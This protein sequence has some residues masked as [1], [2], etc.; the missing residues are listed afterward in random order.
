[1]RPVARDSKTSERLARQRQLSTQA[2]RWVGWKL[3]E[4]GV[5]YRKNVKT[6][7]GSPDFANASKRWAVFVNGC[8]WHHH[9][10]CKRATI[11]RNNEGF[12]RSKFAANRSRDARAV[13]DLRRRGF[14]V[15][16]LW[17]CGLAASETRLRNMLEIPPHDSLTKITNFKGA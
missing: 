3:R 11:P 7:P 2:E 16:I 5:R 13:L 4:F 12:W 10:N 8:F 17:E 15:L 9:T 6:L 14:K 1:M